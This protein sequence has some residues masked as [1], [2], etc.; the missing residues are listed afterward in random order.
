MNGVHS[1]CD[2]VIAMSY[3]WK[4][5]ESEA[6]PS[7]YTFDS[8]PTEFSSTQNVKTKWCTPGEKNLSWYL[9]RK[10]IIS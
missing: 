10:M 7:L 6:Q 3:K 8:S 5:V 4:S 1:T 9:L 2:F